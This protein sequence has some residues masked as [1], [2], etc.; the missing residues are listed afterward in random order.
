MGQAR[1]GL[2]L[3]DVA[4]EVVRVHPRDARAGTVVLVVVHEEAFGGLEVKAVA[5]Q[6][7]DGGVGLH[8]ALLGGD[9]IA[10]EEGHDGRV[11]ELL[12]DARRGVGEHVDAVALALEADGEVVHGLDGIGALGPVLEAG[13]EVGVQP[14]G[15]VRAGVARHGLV[16]DGP[17]VEQR[18]QRAAKERRVE[19]GGV[20]GCVGEA[21]GEVRAVEAHEH[22]SHVKDDVA[23]ARAHGGLL[24]LGFGEV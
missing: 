6:P 21:R 13:G 16:A 18:P 2:E 1:A 8:E 17:R 23:S 19:R 24:R 7:V 14:L 11:R 5:E 3:G 4:G 12:H 20:L 9:H 22:V 10:V 15:Q